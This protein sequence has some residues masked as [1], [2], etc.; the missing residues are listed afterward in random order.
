MVVA[1]L[2]MAKLAPQLLM[3]ADKLIQEQGIVVEFVQL[4]HRLIHG[5]WGQVVPRL[6]LAELIMA[7]IIVALIV[8]LLAH[9]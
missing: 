8:Q 9:P 5:I 4:R 7:H 1:R 6:M 2:V 3:L